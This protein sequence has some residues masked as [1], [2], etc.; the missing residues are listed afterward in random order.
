M[1]NYQVTGTALE[2]YLSERGIAADDFCKQMR[3]AVKTYDK[4]VRGEKVS[5]V[6]LFVLAHKIGLS[7]NDFLA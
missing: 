6:K 3:L 1:M 5:L 2:R 7:L 4:I